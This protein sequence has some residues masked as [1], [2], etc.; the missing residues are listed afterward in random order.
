[1]Y[2]L[3]EDVFEVLAETMQHSQD[4]PSGSPG[5]A[6]GLPRRD[7][8]RCPPA[9][10][11]G[12]DVKTQDEHASETAAGGA[13][14]PSAAAADEMLTERAAGMAQPAAHGELH[15]ARQEVAA[16]KTAIALK[17]SEMLRLK[18]QLDVKDLEAMRQSSNENEA[19]RLR[20]SLAEAHSEI[21][22]LRGGQRGPPPM[23]DGMHSAGHTCL[24]ICE[25]ILGRMKAEDPFAVSSPAPPA[26]GFRTRSTV[27]MMLNGCV[28]EFL[29]VGGPAYNSGQ[30]DRGDT[31][32]KVNDTPVTTETILQALVGED[33]PGSELSLTVKKG[34]KSGVVRVVML[35]RMATER[36]ADRRRAFELFTIIKDRAS[37]LEDDKI[38]LTVDKCIS[39]WT[40]MLVQDTYYHDKATKRF[41]ILQEQCI[42]W[43]EEMHVEL[44][45]FAVSSGDKAGGSNAPGTLVQG[46]IAISFKISLLD[47]PC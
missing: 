39:L 2:G 25:R 16:L 5:S 11:S 28:V 38:P 23:R 34:G 47:E 29:V 35:Q 7:V 30:L 31:V 37:H 19:Q 13:R 10:R 41:K 22:A 1:M 9:R 45:R 12:Q 21:E 15:G 17:D 8:I 3:I 14:D 27:G 42:N 24:R 44:S 36:I 43:L 26:T 32:L 18:M 46:L 40:N 33:T 20:A 4:S 6:T